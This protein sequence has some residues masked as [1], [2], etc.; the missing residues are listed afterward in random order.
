MKQSEEHKAKYLK[1]DSELNKIS[2]VQINVQ[3][4]FPEI[5]NFWKFF[6][7]YNVNIK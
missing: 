1:V 7:Y 2:N 6:L 4:K 5:L 3:F